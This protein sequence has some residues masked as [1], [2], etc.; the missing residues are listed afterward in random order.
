MRSCRRFTVSSWSSLSHP[1]HSPS[2]LSTF[3]S[4]TSSSLVSPCRLKHKPVHGFQSVIQSR[5][6][7]STTTPKIPSHHH[8]ATLRLH[9]PDQG[10][11]VASYTELLD[12]HGCGIIKSEQWTDRSLNL[13]F[14]RIVF[15]CSPLLQHSNNNNNIN[16]ATTTTIPPLPL[17][18]QEKKQSIQQEM[19][20]LS[21][22]Y[23]LDMNLNWRETRKKACI[24]VSKYDHCLWEILLRHEA[25]ELDC[26][27]GLVISNHDVL[28]SMVEDT[29]HLPFH[30]IPKHP[31]HI[32]SSSSSFHPTNDATTT[33][34][35]TTTSSLSPIEQLKQQAEQYEMSL[36]K[37]YEIDVVVLARYMQVFSNDFLQQLKQQDIA[38][39]NIHHSFLPA[40]QGGR[41]YRQAFSRGVKLIGATV[42]FIVF[43]I[44]KFFGTYCIVITCKKLNL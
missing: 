25:K 42:S 1:L 17:L 22:S 29:F 28:R 31:K 30:V 21:K 5:T 34:T 9:G 32:T 11:I 6:A 15:D 13:F 2:S 24:F 43:Y 16:T 10:G 40:F 26:D 41:P 14:Q 38:I 4:Y 20:N 44:V 23:T 39:M 18:H 8:Y 3:L 37:Q 36:L 27:I 7:S 35:S 19:N 33:T 12:R